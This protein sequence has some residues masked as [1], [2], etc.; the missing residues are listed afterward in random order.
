[1]FFLNMDY[2]ETPCHIIDLDKIKNNIS[3]L[4]LLKKKTNIK[5]LFALKGFSND[6]IV[7][8][9]I[10]FFDGVSASSLWEAQL[11]HDLL[12]KPVH[13]YS[14]AYKISQKF[15]GFN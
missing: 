15:Y 10:D 8:M 7:P 9:F 5:I 13:T 2:L 11:A 6:K 1:M 12:K 14:P 3:I 4:S